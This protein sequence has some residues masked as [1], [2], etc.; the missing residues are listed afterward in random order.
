MAGERPLA[1]YTLVLLSCSGEVTQVIPH[2][3]HW[4]EP[5]TWLHLTAWWLEVCRWDVWGAPSF[6]AEVV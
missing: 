6:V 4:L 5:V 3:A 2:T 1:G